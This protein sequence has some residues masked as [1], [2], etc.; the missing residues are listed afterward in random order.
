MALFRL[1]LEVGFVAVV[2]VG[3][4][5]PSDALPNARWRCTMN[6]NVPLGTLTVSGSSYQ[7]VVAKNSLWEPKAGDSGNGSGQ[8][9]ESG[10]RITPSSGP[11]A[12]VY[13]VLGTSSIRPD[14]TTY[15]SFNYRSG[16]AGLFFCWQG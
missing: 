16:G 1:L 6:D 10:N 13:Q 4:A 2:T 11:L 15:L 12:D 7:F 3:A 14:G 8:F 9:Q 5:T